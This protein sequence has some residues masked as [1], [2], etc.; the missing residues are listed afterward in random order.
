MASARL[1]MGVAFGLGVLSV[2]VEIWAAR[3][4]LWRARRNLRTFLMAAAAQVWVLAVLVASGDGSG[5]A[6]L[7]LAVTVVAEIS[8]SVL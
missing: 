1:R 6:G 7:A 8:L 4:P 3:L 2:P 5:V